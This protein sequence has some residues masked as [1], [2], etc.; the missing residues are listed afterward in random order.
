MAT[1]DYLPIRLQSQSVRIDVI[2]NRRIEAIIQ[3]PIRVNS[4]NA[5]ASLSTKF[6]EIAPDHDLAVRLHHQSVH[7]GV[8]V[9]VHT[10]VKGWIQAAVGVE[11]G[12]EVSGFATDGTEV[13]SDNNFAIGLKRHGPDSGVGVGIEAIGRIAGN[14][15]PID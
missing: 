9:G 12:D 10:R 1:N 13:A 8:G 14:D 2:A 4:T 6:G 3:G 15:R 7:T 5:V 11:P